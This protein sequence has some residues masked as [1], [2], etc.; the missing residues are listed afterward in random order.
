[1]D[2]LEIA[3]KNNME[4]DKILKDYI[5]YRC[6]DIAIQKQIVDDL[7]HEVIKSASKIEAKPDFYISY[8]TTKV[9]ELDKEYKSLKMET[10][11]LSQLCYR[12]GDEYVKLMEDAIK[13]EE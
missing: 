7:K 4:M 10:S 9:I 1:M 13:F 6:H 3:T 8:L 11:C 2:N 12:L 5:K